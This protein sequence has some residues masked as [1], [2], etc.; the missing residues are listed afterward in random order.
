M[1][2]P[3]TSGVVGSECSNNS[4]C[5]GAADLCCAYAVTPIFGGKASQGF[6]R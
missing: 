3:L 5:N 6:C 2:S 1:S 4:T